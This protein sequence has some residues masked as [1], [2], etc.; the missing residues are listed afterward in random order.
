M[1]SRGLKTEIPNSMVQW[2]QIAVFMLL[3]LSKHIKENHIGLYSDDRLATFMNSSHPEAEKIE[4]NFQKLFKEK[5]LDNIF[6]PNLKI[7]NY[8]DITLNVNNGS[9]LP[10]RKRNEETN[11]IHV[12]SDYPS[13]IINIFQDQLKKGSQFFNHQ[14]YF[15]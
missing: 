12:N 4:K 11:C 3:P 9:Y 1:T 8:L 2:V 7:T 10:Y 13:S 6:Q 14:K 5:Y 15:S